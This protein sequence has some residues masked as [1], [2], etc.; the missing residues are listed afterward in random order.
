MDWKEILINGYEDVLGELEHTLSGLTDEDLSWQPHPACNSI[1]WLA[2]H[3]TRVQDS[4]IAHLMDEEQLWTKEEWH[5]RFNRP[6]DEKDVG[7]GHT[8]EQ[9]A[10][11][12]SPDIQTLLDY[13]KAVLERTKRYLLSMSESDLERPLDEYWHQ[14]PVKVGWRLISDLEDCLEHA[15]QMAYVRGL[16]QGKDWQKY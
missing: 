3:L 4:Q 15:G 10:D 13:H 5:A 14:I 1:D 7:F 12:K 8:P 9:V 2:W 16:R 11:F 6:A